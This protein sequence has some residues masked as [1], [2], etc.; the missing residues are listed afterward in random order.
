MFRTTP[1][2]NEEIINAVQRGTAWLDENYPGWVN[3]I[4]LD[5]LSMENCENCVIGQAVGNYYQ[6]IDLA[7]GDEYMSHDWAFDHGFSMPNIY[8]DP[9]GCY[10]DEDAVQDS[11]DRL[12]MAWSGVVISRRI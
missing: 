1:V 3:N 10:Y 5:N 7:A 6:T 11:Y 9:E 4:D 2:T 8:R 12:D